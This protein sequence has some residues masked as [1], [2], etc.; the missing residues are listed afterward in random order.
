MVGE[1]SDLYVADTYA[2]LELLTGNKAYAPYL[3]VNL[4]I[5]D[6]VLVELYYALL[7]KY[8]EESASKGFA[9]CL[10]LRYSL[11]SQTLIHAAALRYEYK[12]E[13]L[14]YADCAGWALAQQLGVQFLT[15]D[16]AFANKPGVA[17]VR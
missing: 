10:P 2:L 13:N 12:K 7:R 4:L 1:I 11:T 17:F 16:K 3:Q 5:T 14:S 9:R 8:G 15:G 6:F